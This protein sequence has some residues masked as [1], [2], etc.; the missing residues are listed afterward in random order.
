LTQIIRTPIV[1]VCIP[2]FNRAALLRQTIESVLSQSF[3]DFELIV[4]DNASADNT[5]SVVKSFDESRLTY[6]RNATNIGSRGNWNRCLTLARGKY[7]SIFPDDDLMMPDNLAVKT[8]VL[9]QHPRVGLVHSK[10]HLIDSEGRITRSNTNWGHGLDRDADAIEHGQDV[11]KTMLLSYNVVNAPTVLLRRE[12]YDRLGGFTNHLWTAFDW[13]YWMRIAV[14]FDIAFIARPLIKWR[15]H[16]GSITSQYVRPD[17]SVTTMASWMDDLAAR[18][19]ILRKY[20]PAIAGVRQLRREVR[21]EM[22]ARVMD[23]VDEITGGG[24]PNQDARRLVVRLYLACPALLPPV[25]MLKAF[26]KTM[27]TRRTIERLKRICPV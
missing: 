6:V 26:L 10:Y 11:L 20:R 27:L 1:S 14:Y 21:R 7:I 2:T 5:E 15:I 13:E 12:C 16:S 18:R 22:A 3:R 24:G 25:Q 9:S 19:L 8:D 23:R 4:V 17:R